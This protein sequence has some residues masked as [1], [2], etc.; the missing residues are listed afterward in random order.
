MLPPSLEGDNVTW[1]WVPFWSQVLWLLCRRKSN[2]WWPCIIFFWKEPWR[3]QV[4]LNPYKATKLFPNMRNYFRNKCKQSLSC[5]QWSYQGATER[6]LLF[7]KSSSSSFAPGFISGPKCC[8]KE[9][10]TKYCSGI[11]QTTTPAPKPQATT[12]QKPKSC[13]CGRY[14]N[15]TSA[16]ARIW[17]GQKADPMRDPWIVYLKAMHVRIFQ[18]IFSFYWILKY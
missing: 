12:T 8:K 14:F 18:N 10:G 4:F 16:S 15:Q 5:V 9:Y 2:I 17:N 3:L 6:C 11:Y 7:N 1:Q 13:E